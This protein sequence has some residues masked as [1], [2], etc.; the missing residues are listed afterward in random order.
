[1]RSM[2]ESGVHAW[3]CAVCPAEVGASTWERSLFSQ[4]CMWLGSG[5]GQL[6]KE[7]P[8]NTHTGIWGWIDAEG[9]PRGNCHDQFRWLRNNS[10]CKIW[11]A[12]WMYFPWTQRLCVEIIS[13]V[14]LPDPYGFRV[15]GTLSSPSLSLPLS[16]SPLLFSFPTS[17]IPFFPSSPHLLWVSGSQCIPGWPATHRDTKPASAF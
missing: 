2:G 3:G 16:S 13:V 8:C 7:L 9:F 17:F 4:R 15:I 5:L 6:W 10:G 1:M 14:V 12:L 11:L